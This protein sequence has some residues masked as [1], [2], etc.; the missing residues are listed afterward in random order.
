MGMLGIHSS[1]SDDSPAPPHMLSV[2]LFLVVCSP[3][4]DFFYLT[5]CAEPGFGAL[6]GK[7]AVCMGAEAGYEPCMVYRSC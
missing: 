4:S 6:I 5:G 3:D 7:D 2:L 1:A